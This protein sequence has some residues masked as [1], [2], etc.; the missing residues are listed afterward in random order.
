MIMKMRNTLSALLLV[1]GTSVVGIAQ[2]DV[3]VYDTT[4]T[5]PRVVDVIPSHGF[6]YAYGPGYYAWDGTR[7]VWMGER[8]VSNDDTYGRWSWV[9]DDFVNTPERFLRPR[10]REMG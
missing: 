4:A 9:P 8:M 10:D 6:G 7:Y 5:P 1:A 2:A 3:Y